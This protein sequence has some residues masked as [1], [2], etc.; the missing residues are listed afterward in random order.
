MFLWKVPENRKL[1]LSW[2]LLLQ[3]HGAYVLEEGPI[4]QSES[5]RLTQV[6]LPLIAHLVFFQEG[7]C[8]SYDHILLERDLTRI[9]NLYV[10]LVYAFE[11]IH[12]VLFTT[13]KHLDSFCDK[14]LAVG[15]V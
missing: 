4:L 14:L 2:W 10:Q 13:P 3:T 15:S 8:K 1:G 6:P 11:N 12:G 9:S 7:D 5:K